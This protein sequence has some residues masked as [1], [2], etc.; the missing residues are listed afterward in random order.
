MRSEKKS[1]ER[2]PNK[3]K[4]WLTVDSAKSFTRKIRW[5][6]ELKRVGSAAK[7]MS[8]LTKK[9]EQGKDLTVGERRLKKV[10]DA[11]G[12]SR[13]GGRRKSQT[14]EKEKQLR[15]AR[16]VL[17]MAASSSGDVRNKTKKIEATEKTSAVFSELKVLEKVVLGNNDA[18]TILKR[19]F[20]DTKKLTLSLVAGK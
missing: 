18:R 14:V 6:R 17:R 4:S 15:D 13:R 2:A 20:E 10:W 7:N 3:K 1:A 12:S 16:A 19:M 5:N 9:I 8:E 11:L